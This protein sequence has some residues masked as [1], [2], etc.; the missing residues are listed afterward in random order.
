M[1]LSLF[2]EPEPEAFAPAL[3]AHAPLAERMR[4]RALEEFVGQTHLVGEGRVLRR[5]W[6]G[7]VL[8]SLLLWGGPG[9]GKTT[10]ARLLAG[11]SRAQFVALSAVFAGVK[12]VR[13]AVGGARTM[14]KAGRRTVLFIDEIHR[15]NKSQ[16]DALLPAV[17][18]GTVTLI[19]ATT[20][21]P[22]FEVNG[23]L[24][25]RCRVLTLQPLTEEDISVILRRAVNDAERGLAHLCPVIDDETLA[26]LAHT[27]GG[28]AR[29]A[30]SILEAATEATPTDETG[31]RRITWETLNEAAGRAAFAY[32]KGGEEHYN[33]ASA[34]IKSLR[35]S[36][37]D[38]A[39]YWLARL[40]EGGADPMFIARRL[41][42][43]ASEDIGLADP[44]ALTQAAAA[45]Q[46]THL[47]GLPEALFPLAQAVI[48][49]ARAPK[50]DLV[51][52]AYFAA[53]TDAAETSREPVPLHLRNA[54]TGLMKGLGYGAGYRNAHQDPAAKDEMDC[55]P[56]SLR[57]RVY[58]EQEES[59]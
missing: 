25:S 3:D 49:L 12:E 42:I 54:A 39:L 24:L 30:L 51:K 20:E 22:S 4:P 18:D 21:N 32:D 6:E 37:A 56:E 43:L 47:I 40:I 36:D 8:P 31:T 26:R 44:H 16:Q 13:E 10:L 48:Y 29:A 19:G 58:C 27:A 45:A 38:A 11:Q 59:Q 28:D 53:A 15:F 7:G 33:L 2:D 52:R 41:C 55:L 23:A 46:V 17:E 14:K 1:T 57:G 9:T 5:L 35:N 34:L 50:N